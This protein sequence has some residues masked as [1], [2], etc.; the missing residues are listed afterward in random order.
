[1]PNDKKIKK[2][3]EYKHEFKKIRQYFV[4]GFNKANEV[5]L[6]SFK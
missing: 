2:V 6:S 5:N 4:S 1:M 3:E